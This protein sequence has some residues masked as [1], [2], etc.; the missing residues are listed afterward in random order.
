MLLPGL[1]THIYMYG[2]LHLIFLKDLNN[3]RQ[4]T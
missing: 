1:L 4:R 2:Y 3:F